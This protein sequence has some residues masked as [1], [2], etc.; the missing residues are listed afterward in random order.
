MAVRI[1]S[2]TD[3]DRADILDVHGGTF[4]KEQG[5]EIVA[6]VS[7]LLGDKTVMPLFSLLAV[8]DRNRWPCS[9]QR[10]MTSIQSWRHFGADLSP[11][12]GLE[13]ASG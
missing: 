13:S 5:R 10:G 3:A 6:L 11:A 4:G 1:K 7:G 9:F 12:G 2:A 8:L